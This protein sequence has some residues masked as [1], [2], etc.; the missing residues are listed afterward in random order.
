M[1]K[2]LKASADPIIETDEV[3]R[4]YL[5]ELSL[6]AALASVVHLT[7]DTSILS[8][9][10]PPRMMNVVEANT[11]GQ[12]LLEGGYTRQEAELIHGALIAAIADYR[13]RDCQLPVLSQDKVDVLFRFMFGGE[14]DAQKLEFVSEEVA[15]DGAD[16]VA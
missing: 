6:P 7:G 3:I 11:N 15:L 5:P 8:R 2:H 13:A 12:E 16:S 14:V 9:V 4:G 10:R 1:V